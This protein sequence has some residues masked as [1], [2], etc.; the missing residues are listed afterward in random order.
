MI[1]SAKDALKN[2]NNYCNNITFQ[3]NDLKKIES[4][5]LHIMKKVE[6]QSIGGIINYNIDIPKNNNLSDKELYYI[7]Y[8]LREKGF[9]V[10]ISHNKSNWIFNLKIPL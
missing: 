9:M 6:E 8:K 4:I 2:V 1:F 7:I 10:S 3:D 5:I